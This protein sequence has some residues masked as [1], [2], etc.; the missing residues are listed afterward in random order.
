MDYICS[1]ERNGIW[2]RGGL[3]HSIFRV[4]LLS[5]TIL[6]GGCSAFRVGSEIQAGRQELLIG[7]G[8]SAVGYFQEAANLD[9]NYE[10]SIGYMREGVW[11]YLGRANYDA[12]KLAEAR[13]E[14]ERA[15]ARNER[16][17]FANLYLGLVLAKAE[18]WGESLKQLKNGLAGL[19][20]WFNYTASNALYGQFWD[21]SGAIR[22]EIDGDLAMISNSDIDWPKLVASAEWVGKKTE[23][24]IDL[25]RRDERRLY[26]NDRNRRRRG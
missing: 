16:D 22:S 25:A 6:V 20:E 5:V 4:G 1:I 26:E 8:A 2:Q 14:L 11:T 21:P 19:D 9:P 15:I 12:G 7:R 24:E 18:E 3:V 13:Q 10:Q 17:Y 23:E